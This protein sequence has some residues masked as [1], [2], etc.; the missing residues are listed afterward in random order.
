MEMDMLEGD[1]VTRFK[2]PLRIRTRS[3]SRPM[4]VVR[5]GVCSTVRR[6]GAQVLY[7]PYTPTLT[8]NQKKAIAREQRRTGIIQTPEYDKD[9]VAHMTTLADVRP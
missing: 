6:A 8:D 9:L 3:L 1:T 4:H 2:K 7:T 5:R